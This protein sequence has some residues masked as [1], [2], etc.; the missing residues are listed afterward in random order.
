MNSSQSLLIID[1]VQYAPQMFRRLKRAI[2]GNRHSMGQYLLTGTQKFA[3]MKE[4]GDRLVEQRH[5]H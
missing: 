1:E 2:D 4:V 5:Q 3:L